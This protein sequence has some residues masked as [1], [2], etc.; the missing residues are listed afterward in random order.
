M[1]SHNKPPTHER[2][3][4]L[5]DLVSTDDARSHCEHIRTRQGVRHDDA[6]EHI[7]RERVCRGTRR[8]LTATLR[9]GWSRLPPVLSDVF[10]SLDEAHA[11]RH[12]RKEVRHRRRAHSRSRPTDRARYWVPREP[13]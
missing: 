2:K 11:L 1:P 8:I 6:N 12:W 5:A 3:E 13:S 9:E 7:T 10:W 4:E